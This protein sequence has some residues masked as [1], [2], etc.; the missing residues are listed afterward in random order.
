M[1][2]IIYSFLILS[3]GLVALSSCTVPFTRS[4]NTSEQTAS[5]TQTATIVLQE[6]GKPFETKKVSFEKG[7]D[8]LTILQNNFDIKEEQGFITEIQGHKQKKQEQKYWMFTVDGKSATTGAK[9]TKLGNGQKVVFNLA[10][11]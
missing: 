11:I 3:A 9:E 10:G 7:E 8:L 5:V 6:E 1:K 4:E 2:K